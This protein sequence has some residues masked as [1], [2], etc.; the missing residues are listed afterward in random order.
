MKFL[1]IAVVLLPLV[2]A[3]RFAGDSAQAQSSTMPAANGP[4]A[5]KPVERWYS[6]Q[7]VSQGGKVFQENCAACHGNQGE[8]APEW[9][10]VGADG[11]YP[12]P[13]LN[14]AGHAW[15]HPLKMLFHVVKNGSPGGQ[16]GMPA[17]GE[18]LSNDEMIAA[19]A[20]FQSKWPEQIYSAWIQRELASRPLP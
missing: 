14:G 12:A 16:G 2:L 7:H 6:F 13:P 19:I 9:Q 15:H 10:Q 18:K 11:K 20:W 1:K 8:G 17:W 4:V 3:V 5:V